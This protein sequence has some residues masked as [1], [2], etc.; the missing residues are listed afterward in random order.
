MSNLSTPVI[1]KVDECY[2]LFQGGFW[3]NAE[4]KRWMPRAGSTFDIV[5]HA[6]SAEL[7]RRAAWLAECEE[8]F[9]P[10]S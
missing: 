1:E 6:T 2:H 3:S 9:P 4:A 7:W 10:L 5:C 8:T